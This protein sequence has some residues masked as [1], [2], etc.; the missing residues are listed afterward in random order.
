MDD[1]RTR[2]PLLLMILSLTTVSTALG[3]LLLLVLS[4]AHANLMRGGLSLSADWP[5]FFAVT[6]A[7]IGCVGSWIA[8]NANQTSWASVL[9][10]VLG[11]LIL[12]LALLSG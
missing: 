9:L 1:Q 10:G 2:S 6:L 8:Y 11:A 12:P 5:M 7:I 3:G 4:V